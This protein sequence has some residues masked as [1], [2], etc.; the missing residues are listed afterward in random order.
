MKT[1]LEMRKK[2]TPQLSLRLFASAAMPTHTEFRP[3]RESVKILCNSLVYI[4]LILQMEKVDLS[5]K[6]M[7][8][9]GIQMF[10]QFPG[11]QTGGSE[12]TMRCDEFGELEHFT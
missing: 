7:A 1:G 6:L 10:F 4:G 12:R 3:R 9:Q 2:S 8:G 5:E 11:L